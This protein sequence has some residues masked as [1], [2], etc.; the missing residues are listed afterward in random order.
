ML[1]DINNIVTSDVL[2]YVWP[3]I[4]Y[5]KIRHYYLFSLSS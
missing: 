1:T 5:I 2:G 4:S 3:R